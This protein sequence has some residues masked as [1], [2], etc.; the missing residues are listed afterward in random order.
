[1]FFASKVICS[2]I[3]FVLMTPWISGPRPTPVAS[4]PDLSNDVPPVADTN[5]TIELQQIL[6]DE[7]RYRGR[8]DGV[9][10][11][12]TRASIRG[13]QKAENLPITGELDVH[14]AGKLGLRPEFRE[15]K[16]YETSLD[17][18]SAGIKWSNRSRRTSKTQRM[19]AEKSA[20]TLPPA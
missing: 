16:G 5:N 14:T 19:P 2:G 20:S 13:F 11:L 9:A 12:R 8:I 15:A 7:G 10:G 1:M 17:K 3:V 6:Q 4:R 18:P